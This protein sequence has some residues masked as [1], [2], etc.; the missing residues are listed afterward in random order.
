MEQIISG[1]DIEGPTVKGDA[2]FDTSYQ[3]K[4]LKS[5]TNLGLAK[6]NTQTKNSAKKRFSS[7]VKGKKQK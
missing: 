1:V 6:S 7:T 2:T 4:E 3:S 5:T